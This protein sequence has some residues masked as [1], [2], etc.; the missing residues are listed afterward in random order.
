[1]DL[2]LKRCRD[3]GEW[4]ICK[5]F[6]FC[7]VLF[8]TV[9]YTQ[10]NIFIST[11]HVKT[12]FNPTLCVCQKAGK[13]EK[14]KNNGVLQYHIAVLLFCAVLFVTVLYT[15]NNIFISTLHVK[16]IFNP[17]LCVCQKVGNPEK[18]KNNGVLRYHIAV[19]L[20][21]VPGTNGVL[22]F[23]IENIYCL[24][25]LC[26]LVFLC[27]Y[28]K[29]GSLNKIKAN[30]VLR[31][32]TP[33]LF[34]CACLKLFPLFNKGN[35]DAGSYRYTV[36]Y[37]LFQQ[38]S[39]LLSWWD[40]VPYKIVNWPNIQVLCCRYKYSYALYI[41]TLLN[42]YKYLRLNPIICLGTILLPPILPLP[43]GSRTSLP[44]HRSKS[45]N[46]RDNSFRSVRYRNPDWTPARGRTP[47]ST[48]WG[49]LLSYLHQPY[50]PPLLGKQKVGQP[51][52][53]CN[54]W[55]GRG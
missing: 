38:R 11:L 48:P 55:R 9:P 8:V 35:S 4:H 23:T 1:M 49:A 29:N 21:P 7:A 6:L 50:P 15:Q 42:T 24:C 22:S 36:S 47:P 30:G 17:T 31:Y 37:C 3:G 53:H 54:K 43:F 45:I 34:R 20:Y 33:A 44:L 52:R 2:H 12:I 10:K 28:L 51:N 39:F 5:L 19:L 18:L 14:L 40:T 41:L 46:L 26:P 25:N 27:L 32:N 16:T 13:L